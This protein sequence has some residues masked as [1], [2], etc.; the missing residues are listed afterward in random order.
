MDINGLSLSFHDREKEFQFLD[1]YFWLNLSHL[2]LCLVLSV[3]FF[4]AYAYT[5]LLLARQSLQFLLVIRFGIVVPAFLIVL[6][7]TYV[8]TDVYKRFWQTFSA[9]FVLLS[10]LSYIIITALGSPPYGYSMYVGVIF[11]LI[12]GYT[13]IR[14][15]FIWA[16]LSGLALTAAYI[17]NAFGIIDVPP[18]LLAIQIPI[19]VAV[20]ILGILAAYHIEF[21]ARQA[22]HLHSLLQKEK[23]LVDEAN[24]ELESAVQHRTEELIASN[25]QLTAKL[26]ELGKS[27]QE[28]SKLEGQL[29]QGQ[30]ME[31]VGR[32]A[33][34]VAHDFNNILQA[35]IGCIELAKRAEDCAEQCKYIDEI[36]EGAMKAAALTR[37]LL[38]FSRHQVIELRTLSLN[39]LI[40]N[41]LTMIRRTIGEDIEVDFIPCDSPTLTHADRGQV[42]QILL[43]LCV[44][45]RDAMPNGGR[46]LIETG[47]C[48]LDEKSC[49]DNVEARPGDFVELSVTDNGCGMDQATLTRIFEPFYTSKEQ[50]HGTGLGLASV[51]G[52]VKQHEGFIQV[53]SEPGKGSRFKIYLPEVEGKVTGL[54][55]PEAV[56]T[57]GGT[58]TLFLAEDDD[59]V[60]RFATKLLC[61]SGYTVISAANGQE[62]IELL[63]EN[64]SK[65]DLAILDVVMPR[66]GGQEVYR[67]IRRLRPGLP[68]LF[69]SGYSINTG[70]TDFI[71]KEGL[72]LIQKPYEPS[73]L[74]GK[75][76]EILGTRTP[77]C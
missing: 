13:F 77:E 72:T 60:R 29:A 39:E 35:I 64:I 8:R 4:S 47:T 55:A 41:F 57:A 69:S 56:Q 23:A 16:T 42:E 48:R 24:R 5:D 62:S 37:Q 15:R 6:V 28:R 46:I 3:F 21:S 34:G 17:I 26:E 43:N 76:R 18:M 51:Y 2:R 70:S 49:H 45:A 7:L 25:Q 52:I 27:E 66:G 68:V 10:G 71:A 67:E 33:G 61:G 73:A 31:A 38:A 40:E 74:L 50:G 63:E 30:K 58:E 44:N 12:F 59:G 75:I 54:S 53:Y 36:G 32:L 11:C 22:F 65:V 19:L 9:F 20:N 14:L 1:S